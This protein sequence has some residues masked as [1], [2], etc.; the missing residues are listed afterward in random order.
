M[1]TN[2]E[3]IDTKK[4]DEYIKET[5][6]HGQFLLVW[7][8]IDEYLQANLPSLNLKTYLITFSD[9]GDTYTVYFTKPQKMPIL[10][11]GSGICIVDK[12]ELKIKDFKFA[13]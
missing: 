4:L 13:K 10:G 9:S 5:T 11:G 3:N 2:E 7:N 1:A 12:K 6:V 8:A